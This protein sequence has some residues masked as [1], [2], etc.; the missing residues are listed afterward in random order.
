MNQTIIK[1]IIILL[2]PLVIRFLDGTSRRRVITSHR[3]TQGRTVGQHTLLLNQPFTKRTTPDNQPAVIIL[4]RPGKNLAGWRTKLANQHIHAQILELPFAVRL[5]I[6]TRLRLS[7]RVKNQT[8]GIQKLVNHLYRDRQH[9][10]F[11][12]PQ[13]NDDFP[14]PLCLQLHQCLHELGIRVHAESIHFQITRRVI[15]HIRHIHALHRDTSANHLFL[16]QLRLSSS[17]DRQLYFR[18]QFPPHQLLNLILTHLYPGNQRIV[19]PHNPVPVLYPGFLRRS[20][21]NH[22]HDGYRI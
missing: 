5:V 11:I 8:V 17:N 10:A 2:F 20:T 16:D 6:R 19:H 21:R 12:L 15:Q 22:L 13:I 18:S 4:Y 1:I 9:A 14:H 7:L 3:Q